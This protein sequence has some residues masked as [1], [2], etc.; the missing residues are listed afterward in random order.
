MRHLAGSVSDVSTRPAPTRPAPTHDR[1]EAPLSPRRTHSVPVTT[2]GAFGAP[3][4]VLLVALSLMWGLSFLFI[5]WALTDLTPIWIVALRTTVGGA[6]LLGLLRLRHGTLPRTRRLWSTVLLLGV[7]NNAAPWTLLAWAQQTL[8]SGLA[9]LLMAIVPTSTLLVA[10]AVGLERL[11][12]TRLMG[13]LLA[14]GGVAA[15]VSGDLEQPGRVLAVAAVVLA[16][17]LYATGAVVAK[18]RASGTAPPLTIATGQVLGAAVVAVPVA[19]VTSGPLQL[20]AVGV[21]SWFAVVLLGMLGTGLAFLVFYVLVERV[22]ATNATL[23]AYLIPI[24]AVVTGAL[25]LD[26]RLGVSAVVG[27]VLILVGIW[28]AQR[29]PTG[30]TGTRPDPPAS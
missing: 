27:G 24:V 3:E 21:R 22:G 13:L 9:G 16:T 11:T 10:A 2:V 6:T 29:T 25:V 7:V 14:L 5:E 23:T 15:I 1:T 30:A 4:A 8:P 12:R 17:L 18:Q 20:G 26:E 19:L 28:L